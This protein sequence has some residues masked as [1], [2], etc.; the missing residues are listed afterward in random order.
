[1]NGLQFGE[2]SA[3][4]TGDHP[5]ERESRSPIHGVAHLFDQMCWKIDRQP[6]HA[7]PLALL[8]KDAVVCD[9][10]STAYG[11]FGGDSGRCRRRRHKV[12]PHMTG[13]GRPLLTLL[14]RAHDEKAAYRKAGTQ[15]RWR[16]VGALEGCRMGTIR[17]RFRMLRRFSP[18]SS[19]SRS[20]CEFDSATGMPLSNLERYLTQES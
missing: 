3:N 20:S 7:G 15:P 18:S 5:C 1:M 6:H 19:P 11:D 17:K 2:R 12:P 10:C 16:R 4:R 13:S 9:I 14:T 8:S